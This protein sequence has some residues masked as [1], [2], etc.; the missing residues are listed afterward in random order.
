MKKR[1]LSVILSLVVFIP[2]GIS[3][4]ANHVEGGTFSKKIGYNVIGQ[5]DKLYNLSDKSVLDRVLFGTT[6]SFVEY[7]FRGPF[8]SSKILALRITDNKQTGSYQLEVMEMS[9]A[10]ISKIEKD[11]S[12]ETTEINI[13]G[14]LQ[15]QLTP[16]FMEKIREHNRE[17]RYNALHSDEPYKAYRPEAKTFSISKELAEKLHGKIESLID[18]FTGKGTQA[19][20]ADGN[21][22]TYRCVSGD[23]I[24]SLTVHCP[25]NSALQHS[26]ICCS[27]VNSYGEKDKDDQYIELLDKIDL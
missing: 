21:T 2:A 10:D 16:E 25:Q 5:G 4:N 15:A 12:A 18:N 17:A 23:E 24:K 22:M 19:L 9:N 27:I 7:V 13:P 26:D 14:K 8:N 20:I 1:V 3:Q 6:N 11:L